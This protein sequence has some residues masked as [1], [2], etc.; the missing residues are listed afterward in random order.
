M[1]K[2]TVENCENINTHLCKCDQFQIILFTIRIKVLLS[3]QHWAYC[4]RLC[5]YR[6]LSTT[7]QCTFAM[8]TSQQQHYALKRS[9]KAFTSKSTRMNTKVHSLQWSFPNLHRRGN[10][11]CIDAN[12]CRTY[13]S[14]QS[15]C[16]AK[17]RAGESRHRAP[18]RTFDPATRSLVLLS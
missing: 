7:R 8:T 16:A 1:R 5:S 14:R 15:T 2:R 18:V 6:K 13:H 17:L 4:Y 11:L 9:M 10:T 3:A 12:R